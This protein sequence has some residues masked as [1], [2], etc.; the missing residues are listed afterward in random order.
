MLSDRY[1]RRNAIIGIAFFKDPATFWVFFHGAHWIDRGS[2]DRVTQ[3]SRAT[4][5]SRRSM[6]LRSIRVS[7]SAPQ[8][9]AQTPVPGAAALRV[10]QAKHSSMRCWRAT[11]AKSPPVRPGHGEGAPGLDLGDGWDRTAA[12]VGALVKRA[13]ASEQR[14]GAFTAV[15]IACEFERAKLEITIVFN[16]AVRSRA[17]DPSAAA[18]VTY[19]A[20]LAVAAIHRTH[21]TVGAGEALARY[22]PG[23]DRFRRRLVHG[24]VQR[25]RRNDR[26]QQDV[27]GSRAC[28]GSRGVAVLRYDKRTFVYGSKLAAMAGLTVKD[29]TIDDA[30]AAVK[31]LRTTAAIDPRAHL[32][33]RAQPGGTV[34]PRIG[35]PIRRSPAWSS[36]PASCDQSR[37]PSSISC[38]ICRGRW[39]GDARR[40]EGHRRR[41]EDG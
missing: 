16:E 26:R 24:S 30:L 29:E 34:A 22:C 4:G 21:V 6:V 10:A 23:W 28:L 9:R 1:R 39:H 31:L 41:A 3:M 32:R 11:S 14:R 13:A 33:D 17:A 35:A 15:M 2:E 25:S 12:Q 20:P 38:S 18:V 27:Q 8:I 40:A 19:A 5:G 7:F 37:R 36:W